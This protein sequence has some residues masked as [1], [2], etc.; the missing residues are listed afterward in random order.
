MKRVF[1]V[2]LMTC[3]IALFIVLSSVKVVAVSSVSSPDAAAVATALGYGS[4]S[5]AGASAGGA[6][7]T[8][9]AVGASAT[10]VAGVY[11]G[12]DVIDQFGQ[13]AQDWYQDNWSPGLTGDEDLSGVGGVR[14]RFRF[15]GDSGNTLTLIPTYA[16]MSRYTIGAAADGRLTLAVYDCSGNSIHPYN[17]GYIVGAGDI[18]EVTVTNTGVCGAP[19]LTPEQMAQIG[20]DAVAGGVALP[21]PGSTTEYSPDD[22]IPGRV[23]GVDSDGNVF[24]YPD[25]YTVPKDL[26]APATTGDI[27]AAADQIAGAVDAQTDAV[28]QSV[29][30]TREAVENLEQNL[31]GD[32]PTADTVTA[33]T[34]SRPHFISHALSVLGNKFP[35]DIVGGG[36]PPSGSS[37]CPYFEFFGQQFEA[38]WINTLL[39]VIKIPVVV[40]F[41]VWSAMSL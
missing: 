14:G 19:S 40:R 11:Y 27:D 41:V 20:A 18:I 17:P 3:L 35:L 31:E 28:T 7:A 9:V 22:T 12:P 25:G 38:C 29:D 21:A 37:G 24:D 15:R 4:A 6:G 10:A 34:F 23:I 33:S 16:F 39:D 5:G 1:D 8:V 2:G 26:S 30:A 13:Q 32:A 36:T